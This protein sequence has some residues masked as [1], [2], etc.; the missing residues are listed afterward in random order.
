MAAKKALVA[1]DRLSAEPGQARREYLLVQV[2]KG[3]VR[4]WDHVPLEVPPCGE[5]HWRGQE[6]V[7]LLESVAPQRRT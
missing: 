3:A 5:W 6:Q 1:Q 4:S 7:R 2:G